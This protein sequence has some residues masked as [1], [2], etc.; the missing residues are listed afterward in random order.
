LRRRADK[1]AFTLLE[2][3]IAAT[4]V[5]TGVAL[6]WDGFIVHRKLQARLAAE[7]DALSDLA[8]VCEQLSL[9]AAASRG[10]RAQGGALALATS[11]G[12]VTWAAGDRGLER[13]AG[14]RTRRFASLASGRFV[15]EPAGPRV[16]LVA[17]VRCPADDADTVI[18]RALPAGVKP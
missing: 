13:R 4:I 6:L 1:T 3:L 16:L 15:L 5:W 12:D 9:D 14:G 8:S 7:V 17:K 2:A 11:E 18:A 10:A